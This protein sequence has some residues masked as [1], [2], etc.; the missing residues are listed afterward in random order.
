MPTKITINKQNA[1]TLLIFIAAYR[2]A[3]STQHVLIRLVGERKCKLDN[4]FIV[5]SLLVDLSKAFDCIPHDLM[6]AKL[7][8]YGFNE[9][10]LA[11]IYSYLKKGKQS[12]RILMSIV[13]SK[14]LCQEYPKDQ[15]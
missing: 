2:T 12:V 5:G 15:C 10:A 8:V 3:Y 1:F 13:L 4:D 14:K 6:I 7:H 9:S 11:L